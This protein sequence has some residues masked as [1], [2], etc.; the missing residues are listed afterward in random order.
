MND[1]HATVVT[2]YFAK[3]TILFLQCDPIT[4]STRG[5][6]PT[7]PVWSGILPPHRGTLL[8]K[9]R[10]V[11]VGYTSPASWPTT[12][13]ISC[14]LSCRLSLELGLGGLQE[15]YY[16]LLD[17]SEDFTVNFIPHSLLF[18][19]RAGLAAFSIQDLSRVSE[20]EGGVGSLGHSW[21]S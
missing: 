20:G 2:K 13:I 14:R 12:G 1:T 5:S 19:W 18:L 17:Q 6:S 16:W 7:R 3:I 15:R 21:L 9:I 10:Q 8:G 4:A 11:E